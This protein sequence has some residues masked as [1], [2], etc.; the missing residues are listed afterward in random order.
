MLKMM[1]EVVEEERSCVGNC[2]ALQ[3]YGNSAA[4]LVLGASDGDVGI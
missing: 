2:T 4:V 1:E 3:M